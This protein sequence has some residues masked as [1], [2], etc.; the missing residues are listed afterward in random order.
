MGTHNLGYPRT[1]S[2]QLAIFCSFY[3]GPN[4]MIDF[5]FVSESLRSNIF[6]FEIAWKLQIGILAP[7]VLDLSLQTVQS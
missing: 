4:N 2:S 5:N 1:L 6:H 3:L 7:Y